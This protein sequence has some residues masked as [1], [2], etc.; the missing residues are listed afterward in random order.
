M[1]GGAKSTPIAAMELQAGIEPL[2]YRRDK[3]VLK[4]WERNR[5]VYSD[6][7]RG[8]YNAG[9]K[10]TSEVSP[11]MKAEDLRR[12]YNIPDTTPAPL[13]THC[14]VFDL[15]P[16]FS[17]Q[18]L[19]FTVPKTS[20]L[21][22]ELRKSAIRTIHEKYP[23]K[24]WLHIYTDGSSVPGSGATGAV[25]HCCLFRGSIAVGAPCSNFDGEVVAV[26]KAASKLSSLSPRRAVFLVTHNLPS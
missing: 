22:V 21:E 26:S 5:R 3:M 18:L 16:D 14:Q 17:L 7:W 8:Y 19:D 25:Y 2:Q 9:R 4:F 23:E 20:C 13:I 24:D 1:T 15:L 10:L 12:T 6:Y 11:L